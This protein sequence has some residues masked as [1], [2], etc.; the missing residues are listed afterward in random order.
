M[1]VEEIKNLIRGSSA[2]TDTDAARKLIEDT[3]TFEIIRSAPLTDTQKAALIEKLLL[4]WV[5]GKSNAVSREREQQLKWY[6]QVAV[7]DV[8]DAEIVR[9]LLAEGADK[10]AWDAQGFTI[11]HHAAVRG[12][13]AIV[14]MLI[15]KGADKE[16]RTRDDKNTGMTP[17]LLA[18]MMGHAS[19][20]E[21]LLRAG[22]DKEAKDNEVGLT[23]LAWSESR[24]HLSVATVLRNAGAVN[25]SKARAEANIK[26]K[27]ERSKRVIEKLNRLKANPR[28][29]QILDDDEVI[30]ALAEQHRAAHPGEFPQNPDGSFPLTPIEIA[31]RN[32]RKALE[33]LKTGITNAFATVD[34]HRSGAYAARKDMDEMEAG[35][36]RWAMLSGKQKDSFPGRIGGLR[37]R[38]LKKDYHARLKQIE[39]KWHDLK[40]DDSFSA[41]AKLREQMEKMGDYSVAQKREVL[42]TA[43]RLRNHYRKFL[44]PEERTQLG[45]SIATIRSGVDARWWEFWL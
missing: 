20:V 30:E 2:F 29:Q 38:G 10:E 40:R 8:G 24:K 28:D 1:N 37:A 44:K 19:V 17:L 12:Q 34:D 3:G 13:A 18:A 42:K 31:T 32:R 9:V 21:A 16:A 5:E 23:A 33:E 39:E 6:I 7:K 11:L 43:K 45:E 41:F 26:A 36:S 22:A 14:D 35:L 27:I 4:R 25:T 15:L